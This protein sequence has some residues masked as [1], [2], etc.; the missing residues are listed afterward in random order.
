MPT[1]YSIT[2][3]SITPM[4]HDETTFNEHRRV[5]RIAKTIDYNN[6]PSNIDPLIKAKLLK[7]RERANSIIIHYTHERHFSHYKRAFHQIWNDT[8]HNTPVQTTKLIVGSRNNP[9]ICKK[10]C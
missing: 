8:Y 9:N 10:T 1:K 6:I 3:I 5:A 2:S 7:R 4:I